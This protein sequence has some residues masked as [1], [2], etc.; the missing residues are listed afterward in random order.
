MLIS[1]FFLSCAPKIET[2]AAPTPPN[3]IE[4]AEE[5]STPKGVL[6]SNALLEINDW[7]VGEG[8]IALIGA[9][10]L[11]QHLLPLAFGELEKGLQDDSEENEAE[12]DNPLTELPLEGDGWLRL[13][14][15]CSHQDISVSNIIFQS[16]FSTDG[17][18]PRLWGS[19]TECSFEEVNFNI[20]ADIAFLLP[21]H[22]PMIN[23]SVWAG[24][25][26]QW[27]SFSGEF[28]FSDYL[29]NTDFTV[30]MDPEN[31]IR[32]LWK[33]E[34]LRFVITA[35]L[36][37]EDGLAI[38]MDNVEEIQEL[39]ITIHTEEGEWNCSFLQKSCDGPS[40]HLISW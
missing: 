19:A 35:P 39:G 13:T 27:L 31:L 38:A 32:I 11:F 14:L 3:I 18:D 36:L 26:G 37:T 28:A 5:F 17:L 12:N 30:M 25:E 2:E 4:I 23:S 16:L 34:D 8:G 20:N 9:T 1:F 24:E 33:K 15:P 7:I 6:S 10:L 29:L 21:F 22:S 40:N